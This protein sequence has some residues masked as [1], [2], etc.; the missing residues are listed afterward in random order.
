MTLGGFSCWSLILFKDS[1]YSN[2]GIA[3]LSNSKLVMNI[4]QTG[5]QNCITFIIND[6]IFSVLKKRRRMKKNRFIHYFCKK[7]K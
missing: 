5:F 1:F 7:V 2:H 6:L 3:M 4:I